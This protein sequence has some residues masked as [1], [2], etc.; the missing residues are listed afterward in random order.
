MPVASVLTTCVPAGLAERDLLPYEAAGRLART[1]QVLGNDTRLRLL[2]ALAREG[3]LS[4][5]DLAGAIGMKAQAT[6][7]QLQR[8]V[9]RGIVASRREGTRVIYRIEDPCVPQLLELALCLT[10]GEQ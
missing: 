3:E 6:S 8:L 9:D 10:E 4:V 5:G 7:N 1:F 2:H